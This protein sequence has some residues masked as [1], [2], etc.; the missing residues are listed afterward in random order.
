MI[1]VHNDWKL[2]PDNDLLLVSGSNAAAQRLYIRLGTQIGEY[3]WDQAIGMSWLYSVL[4][5]KGDS[6]AVRQL[7]VDQIRLDSE[8]A[9]T[10]EIQATFN[11]TQRKM[12]YSVN[13]QLID[14]INTTVVA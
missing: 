4:G 5:Q 9:A 1:D 10:G 12:I 14:G 11:N 8:V 2:G 3:R 13:V 6:A 7:I